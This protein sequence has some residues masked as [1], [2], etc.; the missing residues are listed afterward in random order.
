MFGTVLTGA[1]RNIKPYYIRILLI[2][3]PFYLVHLLLLFAWVSASNDILLNIILLFLMILGIG[4]SSMVPLYAIKYLLQKD[5]QIIKDMLIEIGISYFQIVRIVL[6]KSLVIFIGF[7]LIIP[8]AYFSIKWFLA[9][10][11]FII[12]RADNPFFTSAQFTKSY[13]FKVLLF[14]AIFYWSIDL[15]VF[16]AT[17][18]VADLFTT[19]L[20]CAAIV[21]LLAAPVRAALEYEVYYH[22]RNNYKEAHPNSLLVRDVE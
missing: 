13:F 12:D 15:T 18:L 22:L 11:A 21:Q 19:R 8:G 14:L 16:I 2:A 7:M 9:Y 20:L 10:P 3:A 17:D 5:N 4:L 1:W 6:K